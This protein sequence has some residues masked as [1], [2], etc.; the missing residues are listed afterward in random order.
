MA[1]KLGDC[2][3]R[4]F[5]KSKR[6]RLRSSHEKSNLLSR[7]FWIFGMTFYPKKSTYLSVPSSRKN[8]KVQRT[9][10]FLRLFWIRKKEIISYNFLSFFPSNSKE[11]ESTLDLRV[12]A[13]RRNG[14][15]RRFVRVKSQFK[16]PKNTRPK[17][18]FFIS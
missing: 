17:I 9:L 12:F 13:T 18:L 16:N 7:A 5:H 6:N 11:T 10:G 14:E 8:S 15:V 2:L 1:R 3:Q 4:L